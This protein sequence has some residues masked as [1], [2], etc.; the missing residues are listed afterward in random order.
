MPPSQ[1][2]DGAGAASPSAPEP[3]P[4]RGPIGLLV[5][6]GIGRQKK[7]ATLRGLVKGL[8]SAYPEALKVTW[9]ADDYACVERF[10]PPVHAIEVYWADV[11]RPEDVRGTFDIDRIYQL[12][13][14]PRLNWKSGL[15]TAELVRKRRV[16]AWTAALATLSPFAWCALT[17][18]S[19]FGGMDREE[20][21]R[22][23]KQPGESLKQWFG[24]RLR[25]RSQGERPQTKVDELMD[26][27]VGDVFNFVDGMR[28]AFPEQTP[29]ARSLCESVD[30]I[31]RRF[32]AC[33]R[34]AVEEGDCREIQLVAHSLGSVIMFASMS[35]AR[36]RALGDGSPARLSRIYTIGSPLEK[37]RFFW[38]RL[39]DGSE[40]GPA[41]TADGRLVASC[42][43][44]RPED[45][46]SWHNFYNRLDLVSGR[47][48]RFHGWPVPE[49]HTAP[50]LGGVLSSHV[51]YHANPAFLRFLGEGLG[52]P[53]PTTRSPWWQRL[54]HAVLATLQTL[55]A[56]IALLVV[57]LLGLAAILALAW[58]IGWVVSEPFA[59]IGL[60]GVAFGIRM[61]FIGSIAFAVFIGSTMNGRRLAKEAHAR[62]WARPADEQRRTT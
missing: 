35:S 6:H 5:V 56:P 60:H 32:E 2:A 4:S 46:V 42:D 22:D 15:I 55:V 34:R 18:A 48:K 23:N 52:R 31:R 53:A 51:A 49:N 40:R 59:L 26:Q 12:A 13:W 47:L 24:R 54:R 3:S 29:Q 20:L 14:F 43:G 50:A 45:A 10:G 28:R 21:E 33:A 36:G 16:L 30:E 62:Y 61:F 19:L 37:V 38:P 25:E 27:V 58:G 11:F 8:E 17:G 9:R 7:G 1:A 39:L 44:S 57:T 41:I